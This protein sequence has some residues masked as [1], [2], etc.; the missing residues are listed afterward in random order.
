[1][2]LY[3]VAVPRID[4]AYLSAKMSFVKRRPPAREMGRISVEI[5]GTDLPGGRCGP[6]LEGAWC[7]N[8]H[9]GLAKGPETEALVP[10][11]APGA[12]WRFHVSLRVDETGLYDFGGPYVAGPRDERCLGLRW[13]RED[14][15]GNFLLF[16]S[17]QVPAR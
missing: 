13:L 10:G 12:R 16:S 1:M 5:E 14:V 9:V 4:L 8:V 15:G 7:E 6:D 3:Q 17:C 2:R 11:D